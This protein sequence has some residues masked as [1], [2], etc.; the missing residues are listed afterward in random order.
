MIRVD[1][2]RCPQSVKAD[3]TFAK[4][5]LRANHHYDNGDQVSDPR[6]FVMRWLVALHGWIYE[7]GRLGRTT[8]TMACPACRVEPLGEAALEHPLEQTK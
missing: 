2:A 3:P 8:V 7:G 1:C 4:R 6:A 5:Q